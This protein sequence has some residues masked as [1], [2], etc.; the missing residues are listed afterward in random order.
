MFFTWDILI[1][2][3]TQESAP[4]EQYLRLS[5]GVITSVSVKFPSGCRGE[6][7]VRLLHAEFQLVP[8]TKGEWITG[9]NETV[10]TEAYYELDEIPYTLKFIGFSTGTSYA[11]TVTVR[12][13]VLPK[14]AASVSPL[15]TLISRLLARIGA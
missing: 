8:I 3:N 6:V 7:K 12:I 2:A 11:H 15:V 5:K 4:I 10:E 13:S 1:P 14:E 9:D